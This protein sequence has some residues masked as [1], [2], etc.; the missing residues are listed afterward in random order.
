[1]S[2][3]L[4]DGLRSPVPLFEQLPAIYQ[5]M[6]PN[7]GRLTAAIDGLLAPVW[8]VLDNLEEHFDPLFAPRDFITMLASWVGL[9]ID[10]NWRD[11]QL[12]QL[13]AR[14]VELHRWRGTRQGLVA[15]VEAYAGVRPEITETGGVR[16]CDDPGATPSPQQAPAVHVCVRLPTG[17]SENLVRLSRLIAENVPA[18][19]TL[20]VEIVRER[21]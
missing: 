5:Q 6:D 10:E 15:L 19:V 3:S 12:R 4:I 20:T 8:L 1:V 2:R 11:E 13:L 18:H 16:W 14:A 21:A 17:A 9:Q 7:I